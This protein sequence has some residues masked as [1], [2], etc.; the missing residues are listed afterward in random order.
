MIDGGYDS[1]YRACP[2]FWGSDPGSLVSRLATIVPSFTGL[3][4]LD[5]GCGEGKNAIFLAGKGAW[6]RPTTSHESRSSMLRT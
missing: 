5:A 1:G 3:Q 4:V 6:L 2:C